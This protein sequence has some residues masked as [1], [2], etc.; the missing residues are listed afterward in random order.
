MTVR[1]FDRGGELLRPHPR[2]DGA[3]LYEGVPVRE[4]ILRYRRADGSERLELVTLDA[5]KATA[6][7][8]ARAAVTLEHPE[9]GFVNADNFDKLGVG[10]VDGEALVEEDAQGAYARVKIAVRRRD[11][12][13]AI[14]GGKVELSPGYTVV[15]DETPGEHPVYGR[16]DARQIDRQCNHLAIV[17]RGRGGP[18]VRLRADSLDAEQVDPLPTGAGQRRDTHSKERSMK[19]LIQLLAAMGVEQHFDTDEAAIDAAI[20]VAKQL[21]AD[22]NALA[23]EK[24]ARADADRSAEAVKADMEKIQQAMDELKG[25]YDA[26]KAEL[27]GMKEEAQQKA[28]AAELARLQALAGKVKVKTDGL[29]KDGL[30]LAIAKTRIDSVTAETAPAYLDGILALIEK[31]AGETGAR[32]D[33]DDRYKGKR[34]DG[35]DPDAGKRQDDEFFMPHLDAAD[36]AVATTGGA[37]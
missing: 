17:D 7:S 35:D 25:K 30:R 11:A 18:A 31:T 29:D 34:T 13:D 28:D 9:E 10:D 15:L 16:Y 14:K 26:C 36:R 21:K 24:A 5:V 8:I 32:S 27:D 37:K 12:L 6:R 3:V 19:R 1:R 33:D 4:G 20:P 23:A 22:A 2:D